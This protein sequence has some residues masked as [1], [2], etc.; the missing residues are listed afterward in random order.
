MA[1]VMGMWPAWSQ[2]EETGWWYGVVKEVTLPLNLHVTTAPELKVELYSPMQQETAMPCTKASLTGDSLRYESGPLGLKLTLRYVPEQHEWHGIIRQGLL[3]SS[4][5]FVATDTLFVP[6]RPQTPVGPL[7]YEVEAV[8]VD[9]GDH[10]MTGELTL[11][12]GEGRCAAVVLVS[13][14]GQQNLDEELF[15]HKPFR[16]LADYLTRNGVAV[17]R[18]NDRG[19][20][21]STGEVASATTMD[22]AADAEKMFEWLRHHPRV[23]R[24]KVGILGHSEGGAIGPLVASRNRRVA[25]VV[26]EAGQGCDGAE[27]LLQQNEALYRKAG[28]DSAL[29]SLRLDCMADL[30]AGRE[31][32]VDLS[33]YSKEQLKMVGLDKAGL[34]ALRQQLSMPWMKAFLTLDPAHY[35]PK[36]HCPVLALNGDRDVQVVAEPNLKRI[37]ALC[38]QAET[39]VLKGHNHLMQH[40]TTGEVEEY[41]T[42]EESLSEEFLETVTDWIKKT[43]YGK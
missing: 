38:P 25:F 21:G 5:R 6:R 41:M 32:T 34:F 22:F 30:F 3:R 9:C 28:V 8:T 39:H 26:M 23:D 13:G 16:V 35:L 33:R 29:V 36:V 20:G 37:E 15:A 17:L 1:M 27:V 18:Y 19:I 42:I 7:P 24:R 43:Q 31:L 2:Q 10:V 11:P 40:C 12:R 4:V 14:S